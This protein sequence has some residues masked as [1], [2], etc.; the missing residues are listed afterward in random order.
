MGDRRTLIDGYRRLEDGVRV[1]DEE[2]A[3]LTGI[4]AYGRLGNED[5]TDTHFLRWLNECARTMLAETMRGLRKEIDARVRAIELP[6]FL[7]SI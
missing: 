3:K 5:G 7:L 6:A 2:S 1:L 4:D